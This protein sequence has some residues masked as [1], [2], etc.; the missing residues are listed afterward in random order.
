MNILDL[1]ID[2]IIPAPWNPNEMDPEMLSRL[3]HSIQR[4]DLVVPLVVRLV[5]DDVYETIGGAQRLSIL[6]EL[7]VESV[8]CVLVQ[9][10][11]AEARLLGQALNHIAGTDNLGLRAEVL[12][13]IL[14]T[15][16]QK[17]VL[18]LLPET[19]SSLQ[20][21]SSI[22]EQSLAQALQQWEQAQK[23]RFRHLSFQLTD[24]QLEVVE[25]VLEKLLPLAAA[26]DRSP[27]RRGTALYLLCLGVLE[28]EL[29]IDAP[30]EHEDRS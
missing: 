14:A 5:G 26:N 23:A 16:S 29:S 15:K 18:D 19:A 30:I 1:P 27:N 21:L 2:S 4:F 12:R 10:N 28:R 11:D 20:M 3:R 6:R 13:E 25:E 17:E 9:A 22:G 24:A 8:S 7:V